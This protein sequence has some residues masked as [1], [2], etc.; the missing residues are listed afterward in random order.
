MFLVGHENAKKKI[1][2]KKAPGETT[3]IKGE[4]CLRNE[5]KDQLMSCRLKIG[6]PFEKTS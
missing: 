3:I 1:Q 2:Y 4:A 5:K 6:L